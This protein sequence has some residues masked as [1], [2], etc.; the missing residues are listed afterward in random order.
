MKKAYIK[1]DD[2]IKRQ[3]SKLRWAG[4]V[5]RIDKNK[6]SNKIS[7]SNPRRQRGRGGPKLRWTDRAVEIG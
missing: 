7:R 5:E 3:S 6:L 4:H 2:R 1:H